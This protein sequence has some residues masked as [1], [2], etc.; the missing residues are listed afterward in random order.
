M[1]DVKYIDIP[2]ANIAYKTLGSGEPLIMCTGY[3]STMDLWS[4]EL[5]NQLQK[6]FTVIL[7]DYR[8]MGLSKNNS[9]SFSINTLSDD[10]KLLM[11]GLNIR[12]AN[13]LGWSMGG[14]VAQM[15]AIKHADSVSKLI[16]YAT[17]CGDTKTINPKKE[18]TDIL[19]NPK[20]SPLELISTLFPDEWLLSHSEPWKYLPEVNEPMNIDTIKLQYEAVQDWLKPGGGS[21]QHLHKLNI[22]VLVICGKEDKVVPYENSIILSDLISSSTLKVVEDTGHGL[23]YQL[24]KYFSNEVIN[25]L[26]K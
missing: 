10:V 3:T 13:V 11:K 8:G 12:K 2:N 20:S 19:S 24:P 22:P 1:D 21:M 18:I 26:L 15:F 25:F 4:T 17:N 5:I 6:N 9:V 14:F 7:F 23:M 16:L